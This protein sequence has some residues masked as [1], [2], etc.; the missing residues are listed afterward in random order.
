MS[1]SLQILAHSCVDAVLHG[2]TTVT[3]SARGPGGLPRGVGRGELLSVNQE[4][5]HNYAV[6]PIKVLAWIHKKTPARRSPP[7]MK[8]EKT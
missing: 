7:P 1:Y 6:D 8:D 3:V 2:M 4:G 5:V